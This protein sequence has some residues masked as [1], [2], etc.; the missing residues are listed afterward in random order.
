MVGIPDLVRG[1]SW[2]VPGYSG[3]FRANSRNFRVNSRFIPGMSLLRCRELW[4]FSGFGEW[5]FVFGGFGDGCGGNG[6]RRGWGVGGAEVGEKF[7]VAVVDFLPFEVVAAA[8]A[9]GAGRVFHVRGE[10]ALDVAD[11]FGGCWV[12]AGD[13]DAHAVT[14]NFSVVRFRLWSGLV[15]WLSSSLFL[16]GL[17]DMRGRFRSRLGRGRQDELE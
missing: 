13:I 16:S 5:D 10:A 2:L 6:G 4:N 8:W 12:V 9:G 7:L 14:A 11:N 1:F 15:E 3:F 17:H